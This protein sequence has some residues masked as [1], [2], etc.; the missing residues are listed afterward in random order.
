MI[1]G[2]RS[3]PGRGHGVRPKCQIDNRPNGLYRGDVNHSKLVNVLQRQIH[4]P[5]CS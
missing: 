1:T 2:G 4:T 3:R 5:A